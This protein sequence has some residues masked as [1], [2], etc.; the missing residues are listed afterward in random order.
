MEAEFHI[1][2]QVQVTGFYLTALN[3][4]NLKCLV[5]HRQLTE[6]LHLQDIHQHRRLT[7]QLLRLTMLEARTVQHHLLTRK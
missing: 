2:R 1:H 7:V 5:R 6:A 4:F 3:C